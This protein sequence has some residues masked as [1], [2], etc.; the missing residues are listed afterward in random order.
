MAEINKGAID[1]VKRVAKVFEA[2]IDLADALEGIASIEGA[3]KEANQRLDVARKAEAEVA[4]S[5]EEKKQE[6]KQL[7]GK[8]ADHLTKIDGM[9]KDAEIRV[10]DMM[11]DAKN[12]VSN[13]MAMA[14]VKAETMES[15]ANMVVLA[16]NEKAAEA[17]AKLDAILSD[18]A[19]ASDERSKL[20]KA[21]DAIKNKFS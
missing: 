15:E 12:S 19:K 18:I 9:L 21:I 1:G 7:T 8:K 14:R 6:L 4:T 2:V 3:T 10:A 13:T 20:Q 11:A 5:I 16:I 17:Q